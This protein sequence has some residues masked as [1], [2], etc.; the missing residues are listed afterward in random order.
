MADLSNDSGVYGRPWLAVFLGVVVAVVVYGTSLLFGQDPAGVPGE[1]QVVDVQIMGN[2][3]VAREKILRQI[4]TRPGR[5]FDLELIEQDVR[6]LGRTGQ[7]VDVKTFTQRVPGGRV[8]VFQVV[9]RPIL[10]EVRYIGNK[11]IK[12]KALQKEV[13]LKSGDALDPYA[14]A[15]ARRRIEGLYRTRGFSKARVTVGEGDKPGDRR[16][17]FVINEGRKARILWTGFVGNAIASDARLRTQIK[18]KPGILWF[19]NGEVDRQQIEEDLNRLTAYYRSLGFFR[20]RVGRILDFTGNQNWL[21]LTFVIDEG[22][23]YKVRNVSFIGNTK[24]TAEALDAE[25]QLKGGRY[26]DQR[27]MTGDVATIQEKYGSIGYIFADVKPDPRYL[28]NEAQID[29]VYNISEGDRCRVGRINVEIQGEYPH[30]RITTVLNRVSLKP[31][32]IVDIRKLRESERRLRRSGLFELDI[33]RGTAPKIVFSP[34]PLDEE[35]TEIARPPGRPPRVRG[36]SPDLVPCGG[37]NYAPAAESRPGDRRVDLTLPCRR[38]RPAAA[39]EAGPH[40]PYRPGICGGTPAPQP[41]SVVVRAQ[42][43]PEEGRA[44]PELRA[45]PSWYGGQQAVPAPSGGPVADGLSAPPV[46]TPPATPAPVMAP[47]PAAPTYPPAPATQPVPGPAGISGGA[48][49]PGPTFGGR[50]AVGPAQP[51]SGRLVVPPRMPA[52]EGIFSEDS[53]FFGGPPDQDFTREIDIFPTLQETETGRLMFGAGINSDAGLVGSFVIDERNFDWTR[54]PRSWE[55]IRNATAWRGAGQRFRLEAVPG[56]EVQRYMVSFQEPYLLDTAVSLGLSASY[57]DRRFFEW[58]EQRLS[59]RVSLG[60]QLTH[61]LVGSFSFRGAK[62]NIYNLFSHPFYGTPWELEEVKGDNALYGFGLRLAHDTRDSAFLATEGHLIELG[63]EQVIG[64]F[65]YPRAEVDLRKYFL[66][67]ERPDGSGRHVLS[68]S[69][70]LGWTD[71]NTP[72][73]D[74]YYAGGFSTIRGFDFRGASPRDGLTGMLVGGHVQLLLSAQYLFPIT[75]DDMLRGVVFCDTG[76]VE[77]AFDDW[78]GTY[79]VSPGFGLRITIPAMG[80][81]PIALDFAFPVSSDPGDREEVF[82]FFVGFN[83]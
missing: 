25:V 55:D 19:I 34:P 79:R 45:P 59:G 2:R 36:Q 8:V 61:D 10:E 80:P 31:G 74:H 42:F 67:H 64:S 7:F 54:F 27:Q 17:V 62:I 70:R 40:W 1:E 33:Q 78:D 28:E 35:E 32:D 4:H 57:Y 18:S 44:V 24:F 22:P 71:T 39:A 29:L 9:E 20:A 14:V 66:I 16:A 48:A 15:E 68:L 49:P 6:R 5:P 21:I 43:S 50:P 13:T 52:N 83:R 73:Y 41:S 81:A 60:Y 23:R 58:D 11:K 47:P 69:A 38:V 3:G 51:G 26:F 65:N 46:M 37:W 77:R 76:T 56:T 72:I 63:I 82:S 30:T 12:T 53:P 75:A